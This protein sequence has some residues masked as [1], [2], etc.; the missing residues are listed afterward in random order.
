MFNDGHLIVFFFVVINRPAKMF[1]F[2]NIQSLCLGEKSNYVQR[3]FR[4]R[5]SMQKKYFHTAKLSQVE[6]TDI[7]VT[8]F[9]RYY[10]F[11]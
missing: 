5:F 3:G 10:K 1:K 4:E 2:R 11:S 8:S 7:Y 6:E 9:Q